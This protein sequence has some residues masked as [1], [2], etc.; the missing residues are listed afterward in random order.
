MMWF[1]HDSFKDV[2]FS[3]YSMKELSKLNDSAKLDSSIKKLFKGKSF[4][5]F[6]RNTRVR[7]VTKMIKTKKKLVKLEITPKTE[8]KK[9][10]FPLITD[11]DMVPVL[12]DC[13]RH[14]EV[15]ILFGCHLIGPLTFRSISKVKSLTKLSMGSSK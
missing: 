8:N 7:Y 2:D 9:R 10:V 12:N 11:Q 13:E 15:L 6:V 4:T 14:L 3:K 1:M 5:H